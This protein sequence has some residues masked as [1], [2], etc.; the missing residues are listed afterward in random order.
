MRGN[1]HVRFLGE[2]DAEMRHPYPTC[3]RYTNAAKAGP[4][5]AAVAGFFSP[6]LKDHD[7]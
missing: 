7:L 4:E 6:A 2:G 5:P 3:G 1:S